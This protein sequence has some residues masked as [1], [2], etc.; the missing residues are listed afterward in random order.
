M[1][2]DKTETVIIIPFNNEVISRYNKDGFVES[3]SPPSPMQTPASC[4]SYRKGD[5]QMVR[6]YVHY[7]TIP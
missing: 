3:I 4:S 6:K 7:L 2:D 1:P 5:G